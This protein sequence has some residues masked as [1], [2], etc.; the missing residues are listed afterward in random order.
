MHKK[1]SVMILTYNS[2]EFI[3]ETIDSVLIQDYQNYE[4][5]IGDDGSSDDTIKIIKHY[6]KKNTIPIT[7]IE[8]TENNGITHNF[9]K[10]L[11]ACNGEYIFLLGGDDVFLQGKI[12]NQVEYMDKNPNIAISYHDV[13]VFNSIDNKHLYLYNKDRHG[14]HSGNV[15]ILVTQGT[16]NCGCATAVRNLDLPRCDIEIRYSSDWLWYMEIL[17]K[18]GKQIGF[19]DG[20]FA[21]Y[22]RH[23]RNITSISKISIQASEVFLSLEKIVK[24]HPAL[25]YYYEIAHAERSFVFSL[26]YL[27]SGNPKDALHHIKSLR[28]FCKGALYFAKR[29]LLRRVC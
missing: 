10:C 20:I 15:E 19:F 16:F 13:S 26:K 6:Q 18:S 23:S 14:F 5:I 9:N 2:S 4:I 28:T 3:A 8:S 1:V 11:D 27:L 21:K 24:K 12:R 25:N 29:R 17:A 22:R 7:L